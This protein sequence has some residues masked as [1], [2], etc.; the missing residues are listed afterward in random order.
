MPQSKYAF[1]TPIASAIVIALV[2]GGTAPW[3][4]RELVGNKT[5]RPTPPAPSASVKVK[6]VVTERNPFSGGVESAPEF[7]DHAAFARE[8]TARNKVHWVSWVYVGVSEPLQSRRFA[9]REAAQRFIANGGPLNMRPR[10]IN[11][12][13]KPATIVAARVACETIKLPDPVARP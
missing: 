5:P 11:I 4:W 8:C 12:L 13:A 7:T 10:A 1:L 2:V 9:T 3:W 6:Y